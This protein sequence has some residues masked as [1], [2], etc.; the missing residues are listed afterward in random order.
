MF[1]YTVFHY[2]RVY[3]RRNG[4]L[5]SWNGVLDLLEFLYNLFD[6]S[7]CIHVCKIVEIKTC[8]QRNNTSKYLSENIIGNTKYQIR[9]LRHTNILGQEP[10][11]KKIEISKSITLFLIRKLNIVMSTNQLWTYHNF[12]WINANIQDSLQ[13]LSQVLT[14]FL[15]RKLKIV[16]SSNQM[17]TY[18]NFSWM[19]AN[20]QASLQWLLSNAT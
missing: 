16:M 9:H 12:S 10:Y 4:I 15:I 13:R 19:N 6:I 2:P 20:I 5:K 1:W 8:Q 18:H 11:V 14:L 3:P 7:H 17:W